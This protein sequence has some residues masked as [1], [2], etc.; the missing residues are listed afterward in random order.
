MHYALGAKRR[1][2]S[3]NYELCLVLYSDGVMSW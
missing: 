3:K 1:L 2:Q